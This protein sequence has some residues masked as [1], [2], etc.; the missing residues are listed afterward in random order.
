MLSSD[1]SGD[2]SNEDTMIVLIQLDMPEIRVDKTVCCGGDC[3]SLDD[4]NW[5]ESIDALPGSTADFRIEVENTGDQ[6]LAVCLADMLAPLSGIDGLSN[7]SAVLTRDGVDIPIMN[8]GQA[9]AAGLNNVFFN[10]GNLGFLGSILDSATCDDTSE[11]RNYLGVLEGVDICG[12]PDNPLGDK[13]VLRFQAQL[14]D[15]INGCDDVGNTRDL[16][17]T[18]TVVGDPDLP[19][20]QTG[21]LDAADGDE[22]SDVDDAAVNILCRDID[23]QKDAVAANDI[24]SNPL[25]PHVLPIFDTTPSLFPVDLTYRYSVTNNG[26]LAEEVQ[27]SDATLCSDITSTANIDFAGP[28]ATACPLCVTPANGVTAEVSGGGGMIP[29]PPGP[30]ECKIRFANATALSTFLGLDDARGPLQGDPAECNGGENDPFCY[31][32]RAMVRV[33]GANLPDGCNQDDTFRACETVCGGGCTI[34][35]DKQ[36]KC[37]DEAD[38]EFVDDKVTLPGEELTFRFRVTH[39]GTPLSKLVITDSL[40]CDD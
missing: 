32:N 15:S 17:N 21:P 23:F 3:V 31:T 9:A 35:V 39:S 24:N 4:P 26:E 37:A 28:V 27:I 1:S 2:L 18:V 20:L 22:L 11:N 6:D 33:E 13:I 12:D 8:P 34:E 30:I 10:G 25:D 5:A 29:A 7:L 36:V 14:N 40:T 16:V 19:A 38:S